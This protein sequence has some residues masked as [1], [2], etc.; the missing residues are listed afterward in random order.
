VQKRF[1]DLGL[2]PYAS[3]A[4]EMLRFYK[5]DVE[6]WRKVITDAKIEPK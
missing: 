3:S 1:N 5:A 2:S 4:V 6:R